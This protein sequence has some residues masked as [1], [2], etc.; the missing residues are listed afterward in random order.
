MAVTAEA[1]AAVRAELE[2]EEAF[3]LDL[4]QQL[5]RIPTVNPKFEASIALNHEADLQH[6]LRMVLDGFGMRTESY[7]LFPGQPNL[8]GTMPGDDARSLI[9]CGHVDVVP[10]G[11]RKKW[12]VD[13]FG[14]EIR[15]RRLYGRG[16]LDMK[17]GLAANVAVARAIKRAGVALRGRLEIHAVVDEEAGGF[18]ARDIIERGRRAAGVIVTE[19]SWQALMPAEGGLEWVRVTIRGRNAHSAWRYNE[20]FPQADTAERLEPGVN[21][22]E[23]AVR[24]VAAVQQL[25]RDWTTRK[26]AHPLLPPGVNTI[27]PGV[28]VCGAGLGAN[29]LPQLLS[30]PAI[31]P[32]VA[33][34]DFDLKFLPNET[35]ADIR[36]EFAAFV[37]AFAQQDS[38][39]REHPPS[40]QWDLYGLHFPPLN[41]PLGHGLV[42][43]IM[44]A[45]AARGEDTEIRGFTAVCDAAHYAGVGI[46]GVIHGPGGDGF[47]GPDEYVDLDSLKAVTQTLAAATLGWCGVR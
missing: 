25:E 43:A 42:R 36:R 21:A 4:T 7:D 26:R 17:S 35:S 3:L 39:L 45:R 2:R 10:V 47:H 5:V 37:H 41:T 27:H 46:P 1:V 9:L 31:I 22:L 20:I 32:D 38:W 6:Y 8:I 30:N 12:S 23:I 16:A 33:V 29:G 15:G 24:F 19:P 18:G 14:G 34:I 40:V 44:D 28:M 13:P 11:D